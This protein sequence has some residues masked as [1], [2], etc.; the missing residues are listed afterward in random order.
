MPDDLLYA[1]I[2]YNKDE[3]LVLVVAAGASEA[4]HGNIFENHD[5]AASHLLDHYVSATWV[6][7][8]Q[9]LVIMNVTKHHLEAIADCLH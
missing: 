1:M 8:S 2:H 3:I 6:K 4:E 5:A 9:D 7:R